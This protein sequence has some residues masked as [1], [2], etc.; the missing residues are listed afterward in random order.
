MKCEF[1]EIVTVILLTIL[2]TACGTARA[3]EKSTALN[4]AALQDILEVNAGHEMEETLYI[5]MDYNG[6]QELIGTYFDDEDLCHA[7]YCSSDGQTCIQ[8]YQGSNP[9]D[10][11]TIEI[12]DLGEEAH[13]ALNTCRL[14]GTWKTCSILALRDEQICCLLSDAYGYVKM[15]E[16]GDIVLNVEAYDGMYDPD[17]GMNTHTW[18][19]T[20]LFFDGSDYK[21]YGATE[22]P[23]EE[24]L[25]Y[26]NAKTVKDKIDRELR[27]N[28]TVFLK[29]S[30]YIRKNGI[31]HI[32]CDVYDGDEIQYG[33]YTVRYEGDVLDENLGEYNP[34][35]MGT[36]FSDLEVVYAKSTGAKFSLYKN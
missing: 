12:L 26:Q 1:Q 11:C 9:M 32:Q 19:D 25:T 2:C 14:L 17:F 7:W 18:K 28:D 20:Y 8:I 24:Y 27:K 30:Y 4:E 6:K 13:I 36:S 3:D 33:Y 16:E 10:T 31:M 35:Q 21:E 15:T 22:I 34:G 23:E 5:D 29:Y